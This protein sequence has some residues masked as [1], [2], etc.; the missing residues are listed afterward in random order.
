MIGG[1]GRPQGPPLRDD[2]GADDQVWITGAGIITALGLGLERHVEASRSGQSGLTRV[3][4]F[5][6]AAPDPVLAGQAP[7]QYLN[8]DLEATPDRATSLL[9]LA[10]DDAL[11][12]AG[13]GGEDRLEADLIVGTTA[14]NMH[15]G[16]RYYRELRGGGAPDRDLL[17]DF[18]P[19]APAVRVAGQRGLR[20]GVRTVSS[21]CG[22]ASA[23]LGQALDRLRRGGGGPRRV[24]AGGFEALSP[25]VV[26]GFASLKLISGQAC[27]PFDLDRDGLNPG[28]GAALFV[29]ETA[30]AA[31]ARGAKPLAVLAGAGQALEAYHQTRA[32]PAGSGVSSAL[33]RALKQA[34]VTPDQLACLHLHGTATRANDASEFR[35]CETVLGET[36]A[37]IP[38]CSTKPM[39][40]HTFGASG[41]VSAIFALA[42]LRG[43]L[44]PATL[45]LE[46]LD[47][48]LEGLAVSADA[49]PLDAPRHVACTTLGFGGESFALVLS[50]MEESHG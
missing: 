37:R 16:T 11:Q 50:T 10:L 7:G 29:L 42:S 15:G 26:A 6:G 34:G 3:D 45:N 48:E 17:A 8:T 46:R 18:L 39:T 21:A 35:A 44:V 19:C 47:P 41:A 9:R 12:S 43:G 5:S 31:R 2:A 40:G 14:G 13:L 27:R 32:D 24:I 30:T 23:A 33:S 28:E 36:L 49:Q 25:Y 1:G 38:A 22:S 4:F 20:G